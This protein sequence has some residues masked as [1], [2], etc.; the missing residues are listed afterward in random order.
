VATGPSWNEGNRTVRVDFAGGESAYLK[1]ATGDDGSRLAREEAVL[2][3]VRRVGAVPAPRVLASGTGDVPYLFTHPLAGRS[4]L[5]PWSTRGEAGRAALARQVG[6]ALARVHALRFETHG[7]VVGEPTALTL[8]TKPWA[9]ALRETVEEL[10]AIAP[11]DRFDHHYDAVLAAVES[12]RDLLADAPAALCHG[13]V[14]IPNCVLGRAGVGLL[15]WEIAHVGDPARDLY[16]ARRLQLD[17]VRDR[18]PDRLVEAF[19]DG[20][21]ARAGGLPDGF[22]ARRPVYEAVWF[23]NY[24]GFFEN[25]VEFVGAS[26]EEFADWVR[27]GMERR[28]EAL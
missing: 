10:R 4:L 27:T 24:A 11:S 17:G 21:R 1:L 15:D 6:K 19:Y 22:E 3:Y 9:D 26:T 28:L 20:Y 13:D 23:L 25:W 12:K 18:G 16:R 5:D 8:D 2:R 14:A 7:R